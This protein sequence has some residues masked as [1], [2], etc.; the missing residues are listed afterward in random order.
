MPVFNYKSRN[1]IWDFDMR[2]FNRGW[3]LN[4]GL[5]NRGST[6]FIIE[7]SDHRKQIQPVVG[8]ELKPTTMAH[9]LNAKTP[10]DHESS[11]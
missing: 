4:G 6:V 11:I 2:P 8:T 5:L 7:L 9:N 1:T 10:L 3:R